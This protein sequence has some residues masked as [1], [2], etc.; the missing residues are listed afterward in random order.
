[1]N[2][3]PSLLERFLSKCRPEPNSGCWLWT[4]YI[5]P[6]GYGSFRDRAKPEPPSPAHVVSYRL[7]K[8]PVPAGLL[9]RHTCDVRC[10]N[11]DHL[12]LG[13]PRDVVADAVE[14]GPPNHV[15]GDGSFPR[16][17]SP[18]AGEQLRHQPLSTALAIGGRTYSNCGHWG[19][20]PW[21]LQR[22]RSRLVQRSNLG[23][24][25]H[26]VGAA[27]DRQRHGEAKLPTAHPLSAWL[28]LPN[29]WRRIARRVPGDAR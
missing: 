19:R 5:S 3:F 12:L 23:L 25:D 16:K 26:L 13:T 11:P 20:R 6:K 14:R 4:G 15:R 2:K 28:T 21:H 24:L 18:D 17:R 29:L 8:G 7:F 27:D 9:V 22:A 1:V 10:V